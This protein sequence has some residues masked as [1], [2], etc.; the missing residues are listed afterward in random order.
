VT[1]PTPTAGAPRSTTV[2]DL[3]RDHLPIVG[4]Q[5]NE[6]M[7][8]LPGHV[9]RDDLMS[10]GL[11]ALAQAAT[12]YDATTG[13]PFARYATLRIRGAVL[14]ELRA[15]DWAPRGARSRAR[16]LDGVE[17]KLT[18]Q[19][20]RRP[21]REELAT[22]LGCAP[23]SVDAVR[24]D[25]QRSLLSIDAYD[26]TLGEVLPHHELSPEEHLLQGEQVRYLQAA[27]A[28]LPER[29]RTVV[30]GLFL[31]DRPVVELALELGVTESRISQLRSEALVLM[32]DGMNSAL[33]PTLVAPVERPGGVVDRRRQAYFAAV[34]AHAAAVP[35]A[36]AT[37]TGEP[38]VPMQR[39][40]PFAALA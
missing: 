36:T 23:E 2:E 37:A 9:L 20:G 17:E 40:T 3:V 29:L 8:R 38:S 30:Q 32:K 34:A 39:S 16:A 18:A 31:D 21:T 12:S 1:A 5:V 7:A 33:E 15:M 19:L 24:A 11:A 28:A 27:V 6:T 22:A 25:A 26:G 14:D 35:S 10:A 13:V 4:Y